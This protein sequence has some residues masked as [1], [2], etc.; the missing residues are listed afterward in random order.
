MSR[1]GTRTSPAGA[2]AGAVGDVET[3]AAA[4]GADGQA[5]GGGAEDTASQ[6]A[7][8]LAEILRGNPGALRDI[9]AQ[10]GQTTGQAAGGA[11]GQVQEKAT[12]RLDQQKQNL[13]EGLGSVAEGV[14]QMGENLGQTEQGGVVALTARY[15]DSL[16]GHLERFSGYLSE[17]EVGD[18]VYEAEDY[19][20][21]HSAYFVGG[22][23]LLG[24]LGARFLKSST[25]RRERHAELPKG[26]AGSR[27]HRVYSRSEGS[28]EG[29]ATTSDGEG[30]VL[31]GPEGTL[32]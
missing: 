19:A 3:A 28:V 20:R 17:R 24:L 29:L 8:Q 21:R 2:T 4:G 12:S 6:L 26:S 1:Q 30:Q 25:P 18:L 11:A 16:A 31:A 27:T 9:L 13:V 5:A 23:F 22:A 10:A 7:A 14:R 15:G 32:P